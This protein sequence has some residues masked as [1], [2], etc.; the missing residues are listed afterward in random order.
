VVPPT[1]QMIDGFD[2]EATAKENPSGGGRDT[3]TFDN[4]KCTQ[5]KGAEGAL[6][7][8]VSLPLQIS[9]CGFVEH[10]KVQKTEEKKGGKPVVREELLPMDLSGFRAITFQVKSADEH[11]HR[12]HFEVVDHDPGGLNGQG[13]VWTA[14]EILIAKPH[15]RRFEFPIADIPDGLRASAVRSL[16]FKLD[17][18]DGFGE[19]FAVLLDNVA[20]VR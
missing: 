4:G 7:L 10:L 20:F 16:G 15:W 17:G 19:P 3:W 2:G 14:E 11:P 12:L 13:R 1:W 9:Q 5:A 18:R 6:R 8:E